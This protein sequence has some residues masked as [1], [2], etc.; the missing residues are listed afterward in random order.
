VSEV[1]RGIAARY[2]SALKASGSLAANAEDERPTPSELWLWHLEDTVSR[3]VEHSGLRKRPD[4]RGGYDHSWLYAH[5]V[6]LRTRA[7]VQA[8]PDDV[9]LEALRLP[10]VENWGWLSYII[11]DLSFYSL[12]AANWGH[13]AVTTDYSPHEPGA[14]QAD[15]GERRAEAG[16]HFCALMRE[17]YGVDPAAQ[18][19]A[20]LDEVRRRYERRTGKPLEESALRAWLRRR[21][22]SLYFAYAWQDVEFRE[23]VRIAPGEVKY[24]GEQRARLL[25]EIREAAARRRRDRHASHPT[26][27]AERQRAALLQEGLAEERRGIEEGLARYPSTRDRVEQMREPPGADM[28]TGLMRYYGDGRGSTGKD[29]TV[30]HIEILPLSYYLM[31]NPAALDLLRLPEHREVGLTIQK[32]LPWVYIPWM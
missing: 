7:D 12:L 32:Y 8:A 23:G 17:E 24:S 31:A 13:P 19:R 22:E 15:R 29:D 20:P 28:W 1:L 3:I 30:G 21:N 26:D 18:V 25:R 6:C 4:P 11:R 14:V 27:C 9:L 5:R 2:A 16:R 10:R